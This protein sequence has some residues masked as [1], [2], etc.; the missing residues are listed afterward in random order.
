VGLRLPG[1][2]QE[3]FRLPGELPGVAVK[4]A[5]ADL[6]KVVVP[7]PNAVLLPGQPVQLPDRAPGPVQPLFYFPHRRPLHFEGRHQLLDRELQEVGVPVIGVGKRDHL[8]PGQ[9]EGLHQG[10]GVAAV[11]LGDRDDGADVRVLQDRTVDALDPGAEVAR[12]AG[13]LGLLHQG[14]GVFVGNEDVV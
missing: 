13:Q 7:A 14:G 11:P 6:E 9:L 1:A 3:I 4:V 10:V 8:D 5:G 12:V 2:G